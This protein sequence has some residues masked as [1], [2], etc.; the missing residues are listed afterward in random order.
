MGQNPRKPVFNILFVTTKMKP[1]CRCVFCMHPDKISHLSCFTQS[2]YSS[3]HLN[4]QKTIYIMPERKNK[5]GTRIHLEHFRKKKDV[6]E[7]IRVSNRGT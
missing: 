2:P 4:S 3:D 1:L 5:G 7:R 6:E